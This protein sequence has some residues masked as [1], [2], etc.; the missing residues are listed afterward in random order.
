MS[1]IINVIFL[2]WDLSITLNYLLPRKKL[3]K[4]NVIIKRCT[5][6]NDYKNCLYT[7][8]DFIY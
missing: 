3:T 2:F 7:L 6:S 8:L 1:S 4:E 5:S